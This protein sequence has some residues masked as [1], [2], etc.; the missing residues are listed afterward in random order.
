LENFVS[1]LGV[2]TDD[3]IGLQTAWSPPRP[4]PTGDWELVFHQSALVLAAGS[5]GLVVGLSENN[6]SFQQFEALRLHVTA[7]GA[8]G[9][10]AATSGVG[11]VLNS[12]SVEIRSLT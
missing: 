10:Y 8:V 2:L 9:Y 4:L 5:Y 6:Q 7:E 11:L 1:G 12:M 3:G